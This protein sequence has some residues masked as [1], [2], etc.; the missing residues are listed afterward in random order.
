[1]WDQL[2]GVP[3]FF[4]LTKQSLEALGQL[5]QG[6]LGP[7]ENQRDEERRKLM[8]KIKSF[9]TPAPGV[10]G[11]GV[12]GQTPPSMKPG[13]LSQPEPGF[14]S[15]NQNSLEIQ[16]GSALAY[17]WDRDGGFRMCPLS[18]ALSPHEDGGG[19]NGW[20]L[21]VTKGCA[22]SGLCSCG[23]MGAVPGDPTGTVPGDPMG[24]VPVG[25]LRSLPVG[26]T[27][28]V[29]MGP[30]QSSSWSR[31]MSPHANDAAHTRCPW[32]H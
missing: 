26:A 30:T 11:K 10:S 2:S 7:L 32:A 13:M 14:A 12:G 31:L 16:G 29:P 21:G 17:P 19:G 6:A 28:A 4:D 22:G 27:G 9:P 18:P 3:G 8:F 24:A 5:V 1:M 15:E 25:L 23:P 20:G